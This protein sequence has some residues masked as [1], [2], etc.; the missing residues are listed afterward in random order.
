M[1]NKLSS[2]FTTASIGAL[3]FLAPAPVDAADFGGDCCADLEEC[4][5][6]LEATTARK[7]NRK[8]SLTVG[9]HVSTAVLFWDDGFEDNAYVVGNKN[10]QSNFYFNGEAAIS[11]DVTAGFAFTFRLRDTLSDEVTQDLD[12]PEFGFTL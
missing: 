12:D 4:V 10:D 8:V 9:G 1:T 7:G 3:L 6:E 5:A 11:S 2:L